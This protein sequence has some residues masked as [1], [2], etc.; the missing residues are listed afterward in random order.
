MLL[1]HVE[2]TGELKHYIIRDI[3]TIFEETVQLQQHWD[4]MLAVMRFGLARKI[5]ERVLE[6]GALRRE[7]GKCL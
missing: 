4:D 1:W 5:Q 3:F 6:L 2:D 7:S